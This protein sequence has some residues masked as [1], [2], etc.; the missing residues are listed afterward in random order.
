VVSAAPACETDLPGEEEGEGEGTGGG[1]EAGGNGSDEDCTPTA[2]DIDESGCMA[3]DTDYS[4][5]A[6]DQY[7]ACISDGGVYERFDAPPGS[8]GRVAAYEEIAEL[9]WRNGTPSEDDFLDARFKLEEDE[10]LGSRVER[11]EDLH[12]PPI[13]E[14]EHN[15]GLD[16]DKQCS[17]PDLADKYPDRCAGP[18]LIDPLVAA[19]LVD[20]A[21]GVGDPE[22]NAMCV[23]AGLLWFMYISVYK[24]SFT[25]VAKGK[26]CDSAWAYYTGGDQIDGGV[27]LAAEVKAVSGNA[28]EAIFN[29]V[30]G[31]R[32]WRDL[33]PDV[34]SYPTYEDLP[35]ESKD[36][37]DDAWEQLDNALHRG[38][39]VVVR[40]HLTSVTTCGSAEWT[41]A[42]IAGGVLDREAQ[43]RSSADA[44]EFKDILAKDTP[45]TADV[46]RAIELLDAI[47]PCPQ[48]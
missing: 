18:T 17:D 20:G 15:E 27:G 3:L 26:D 33:W 22:H 47:F 7:E 5:G 45:E 23:K 2:S 24:E 11:R 41:F 42:Q 1:H 4:P 40:D 6:D 28:H 10:G 29:G 31:V 14:A 25:C 35:V 36:L 46:E 13:P 38:F 43:E 37:Y 21:Q 9:L 12:Y 44:D 16:P 34:D 48:P 39:A 8:I 30:L 19:A 32:C